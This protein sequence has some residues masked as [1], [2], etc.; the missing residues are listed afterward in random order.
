MEKFITTMLCTT[1]FCINSF[2][3]WSIIV[4]DPKTKEIGIAGASCTSNC[5]GIGSI[6]PGRGAIIVQAMSNY[7]AHDMG[8]KAIIAGHPIEGILAA[9][10]ESRFHPEHQ[11]YAII[12]L[13]QMNPVTYTGDST[14]FYNGVLTANGISVQGNLLSNENVLKA[15]FDEAVRAR[16]DSLSVPEILMRALEIGSE[17]GGDKRCGEQRAQSAFIKV[18]RPRDNA[19]NPY[20]NLVIAS[21]PKG[22][23]NAVAVLRREYEKWKNQELNSK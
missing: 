2:A 20:L 14:I 16:R 7:N 18:A 23:N 11:Q 6:V 15:I 13:K 8:R 19:E 5:S 10:R 22:G 9:L 3:T 21:Q 4:I 1:A 17:A 12:T